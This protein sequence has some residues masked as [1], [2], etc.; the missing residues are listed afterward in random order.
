MPCVIKLFSSTDRATRISLLRSLHLFIEHLTESLVSEKIFPQL[1]TGFTDSVPAMREETVKAML[2]VVPKLSNTIVDNQ[3]LRFFAKLQMDEAP[4]IRVNTTICLGKIAPYLTPESRDRVLASAFVRCLKVRTDS[5][6]RFVCLIL[7]KC[8]NVHPQDNFSHARAAGLMAIKATQNFFSTTDLVRKV[9]PGVVGLTL[10]PDE[11][12]KTQALNLARGML[13]RIEN[14][15]AE[16]DMTVA[17]VSSAMKNNSS[18]W[19]WASSAVTSV[20]S[21]TV[22]KASAVGGAGN[23]SGRAGPASPTDSGKGVPDRHDA[24]DDDD[25]EDAQSGPSLETPPKQRKTP[26]KKSPSSRLQLQVDADDGGWGDD[27]DDDKSDYGDKSGWGGGDA[28]TWGNDDGWGNDSADDLDLD[29]QSHGAPSSRSSEPVTIAP[30]TASHS[31]SKPADS[32]PR[33]G[34]IKLGKKKVGGGLGARKPSKA[35]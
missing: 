22:L 26:P 4:S 10:D 28:D 25:F 5:L 17:A 33:S 32:K 35:D 8:P 27:D 31:T 6:L 18:S 2:L 12:V 21:K 20:I 11:A 14:G 16:A 7:T 9:F 24:D 34:G 30:R 3:L 15:P 13:D 1:A 29:Q 23:P 19:A